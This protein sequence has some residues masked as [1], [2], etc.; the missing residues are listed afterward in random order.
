[1]ET[2]EGRYYRG[3]YQVALTINSSLDPQEVMRDIAESAAK[4]LDAKGASIMLLSPD[5]KAL[6]HSA[7]YGLSDWY[8][9]K[10]SMR[11]DDSMAASLEG[12]SVAIPDVAT[13]PRIQYR[14]QAV[15]EGIASMLSVPVRLRGEVIGLVRLY[16]AAPRQ[17]GQDE[18]E[19]LEAVA[20]LGAIAMENARRYAEVKANYEGVREDLLEWY[21]TWGLERSADA[22]AGGVTI[23]EEHAA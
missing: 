22:L 23:P 8:V 11:V 19:F 16:S 15:Q 14:P 3:L 1:M 20:N 18:I 12:R 2:R 4:A 10:G 13:D 21:A 9:R 7:A 5:R 6:Y 17:F